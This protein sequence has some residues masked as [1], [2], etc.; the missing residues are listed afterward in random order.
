MKDLICNEID[1]FLSKRQLIN[2]FFIFFI[3]IYIY[4][5]YNFRKMQ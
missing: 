2:D 1:R 5:Y 4:I 3:K